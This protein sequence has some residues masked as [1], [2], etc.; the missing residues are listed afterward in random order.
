MLSEM[1]EFRA[2]MWKVTIT[3]NAVVIALVSWLFTKDF[4]FTLI[5]KVLLSLGIT[6]FFATCLF[7]LSALKQH[8]TDHAVV[9]NRINKLFGVYEEGRYI[10]GSALIDRMPWL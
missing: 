2:A 8:F 10:E 9:A 5:H 4:D 1:Q 6:A 7:I 3:T